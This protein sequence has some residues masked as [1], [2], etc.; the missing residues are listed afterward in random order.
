M[1]EISLHLGKR[2]SVAIQNNLEKLKTCAKQW[3]IRH[4]AETKLNDSGN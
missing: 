4:L 1:D 3:L 2:E